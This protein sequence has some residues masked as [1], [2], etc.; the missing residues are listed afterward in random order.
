[1][2]LK[3]EPGLSDPDS[4]YEV[5]LTAHDGLTFE[6]SAALNARLILILANQIGD[7]E[8]LTAAIERAAKRGAEND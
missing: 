5:V 7:Q 4:F 8:T 3:L 6:E 1:M 2:A